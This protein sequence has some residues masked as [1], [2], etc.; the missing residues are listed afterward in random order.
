MT[1]FRVITS[2]SRLTD[3]KLG[4]QSQLVYDSLNANPAFVWEEGVMAN[5]QLEITAYLSLLET[6]T[7][8]NPNDVLKKNIAKKTLASDMRLLAQEV[9]IQA[10]NDVVKLQSSGFTLAKNP[11]KVGPLPKPTNFEVT[12][13][14]NT[15]ELFF[16]VD[17]N[18]KCKMYQFFYTGMP[19]TGD[20]GQMH[21]VSATTHRKNITGFTPGTQYK[22]LC[23]Y[24]GSEDTLVYSEPFYIYAQ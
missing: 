13:G 14:L 17:A 10:A 7:N 21:Q 9:N 3:A 11:V 20:N 24:Q 2:Y 4:F 8:G 1:T 23:A 5:F 18:T 12:S 19:A 6:V 15:G 22:C 16:T